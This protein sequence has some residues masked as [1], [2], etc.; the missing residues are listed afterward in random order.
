M[1]D[2][3]EWQDAAK[4][5]NA[6]TNDGNKNRLVKIRVTGEDEARLKELAEKEGLTLSEYLRRRG[7][8]RRASSKADNDDQQN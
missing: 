2:S 3:T 7:L 8:R 5:S 4:G 1:E 6:M